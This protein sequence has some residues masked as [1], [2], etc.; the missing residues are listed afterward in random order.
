ML[1]ELNSN[2]DWEP[3]I[4]AQQQSI[5]IGTTLWY[6]YLPRH[7][8]FSFKK[9]ASQSLLSSQHS[10]FVWTHLF[11]KRRRKYLF[12]R[13][14]TWITTDADAS[15]DDSSK[16]KICTYKYFPTLLVLIAITTLYLFPNKRKLSTRLKATI[17]QFPVN[18]CYWY[19]VNWE[20]FRNT[21]N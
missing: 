18:L 15:S 10:L 12:I 9:E 16:E 5:C 2:L 21:R 3:S 19:D 1:N 4:S 8:Y 11:A 7:T 20:F 14:R 6:S 13:A 17:E